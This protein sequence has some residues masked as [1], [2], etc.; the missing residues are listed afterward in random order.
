MY[1]LDEIKELINTLDSSGLTALEIK[2]KYGETISIKKETVKETA[3]SRTNPDN[4][5]QI[6]IALSPGTSVVNETPQQAPVQP[7]YTTTKRI[8][9]DEQPKIEKN[10]DSE[11]VKEDNYKT[12]T[13]PMVGVFYSSP[14]PDADPYISVGQ[15]INNGDIV[16]IIEAMK[17]MNEIPATESGTIT[18]IC[19]NNGDIVEFGQPLFKVK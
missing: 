15:T 13:S 10:K 17:L 11:T 14:S 1:T 3:I 9:D 7:T 18:E 5:P 16:C 2:D 8:A 19:V 4:I 6:A 12:I